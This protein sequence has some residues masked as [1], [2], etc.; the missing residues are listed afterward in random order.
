MNGTEW[1]TW[2]DL[3]AVRYFALQRS[4]LEIM[5]TILD[6]AK[7]GAKKTH[8]LH[9]SYLSYSKYNIYLKELLKKGL[10]EEENENGRRLYWTTNK[11]K[12]FLST[13]YNL[14]LIDESQPIPSRRLKG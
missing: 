14:G 8:L 9:G 12:D 3:S 7:P 11:G 1:E 10:L 5:A 2:T 13:Y 6:L 4:R